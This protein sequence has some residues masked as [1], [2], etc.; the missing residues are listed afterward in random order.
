[1]GV[2]T[3]KSFAPF[4]IPVNYLQQCC[5][6]ESNQKIVRDYPFDAKILGVVAPQVADLRL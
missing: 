1:M 3:R 6:C 5:R 4:A 2:G